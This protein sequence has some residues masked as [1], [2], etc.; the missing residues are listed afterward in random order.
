MKDIKSGF[1]NP[2]ES[3]EENSDE[4]SEHDKSSQSK[5][6]KGSNNSKKLIS[7]KVKNLDESS[8]ESKLSEAEGDM[9]PVDGW[10]FTGQKIEPRKKQDF[11]KKLRSWAAYYE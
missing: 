7:T 6:S 11:F 4:E 3:D 5:K 1:K 2:D 10:D 8:I 9:K